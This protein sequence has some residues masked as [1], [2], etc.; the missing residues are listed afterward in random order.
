MKRSA[1]L[2]LNRISVQEFYEIP[3]NDAWQVPVTRTSAAIG[4]AA[5]PVP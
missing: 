3:L 2:E 1:C 5:I 4:T